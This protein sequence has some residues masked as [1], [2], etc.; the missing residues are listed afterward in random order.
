[1]LCEIVSI[2]FR[3]SKDTGK[4]GRPAIWENE[5]INLVALGKNSLKWL[6]LRSASLW[7]LGNHLSYNVFY[8]YH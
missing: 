2:H 8:K 4:D 5:T 1:M 6:C 7:Y 3:T